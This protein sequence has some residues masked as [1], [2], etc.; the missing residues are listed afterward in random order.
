MK[1]KTELSKIA[2]ELAIDSKASGID[3]LGCLYDEDWNL[4]EDAWQAVCQEAE[5][6]IPTVKV[7]E[8]VRALWA[9]ADRDVRAE[10]RAEQRA[11]G[12]E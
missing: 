11:F 8:A 9:Q 10:Q 5:A 12:G 2:R 3:D 4:D 1:T 6:L 7:P